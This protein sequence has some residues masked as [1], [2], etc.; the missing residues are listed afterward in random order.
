[1]TQSKVSS[2]PSC[3]A[4]PLGVAA[5]ALRMRASEA[6]PFGDGYAEDVAAC[7]AQRRR[8]LSLRWPYWPRSP[9]WPNEGAEGTDG[10]GA[11]LQAWCA[12][13]DLHS[14]PPPDRRI[15]RTGRFPGLR[16]S[17]PSSPGPRL[18]RLRPAGVPGHLPFALASQASRRFRKQMFN[19]GGTPRRKARP[20]VQFLSPSASSGSP[21]SSP[22]SRVRSPRTPRGPTQS[23]C[24]R[25]QAARVACSGK[26]R[27]TH[28][29]P[30]GRHRPDRGH[31]RERRPCVPGTLETGSLARRAAQR[32]DRRALS[33]RQ[34]A[35]AVGRS[36]RAGLCVQRLAHIQ[37]GGEPG[38]AGA[39]GRAGRDVC[40]LRAQGRQ[41]RGRGPCGDGGG[42][43]G[44]SCARHDRGASAAAL[45]AR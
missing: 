26:R 11:T 21:V 37:A 33:R 10:S 31:A 44:H 42:G 43:R 27:G 19:H 2:T 39:K 13:L 1:M 38:R 32:E 3:P 34:C 30:A 7:A 25:R 5:T 9:H 41:G 18:A 36:D 40:V 4:T 20:C 22:D 35:A 23:R 15:S 12:A 14:K 6:P 8:E 24:W 17:P 28:G 16:A 45:R 29:R